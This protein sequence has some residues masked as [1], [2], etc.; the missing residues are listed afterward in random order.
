[1]S[2]VVSGVTL[3]SLADGREV[4][5]VTENRADANS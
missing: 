1:M 3:E 5:T 2:T 4:V